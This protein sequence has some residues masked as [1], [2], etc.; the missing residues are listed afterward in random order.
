MPHAVTEVRGGLVEQDDG[1]SSAAERSLALDKATVEGLRRWKVRQAEE[2]LAAGPA[3]RDTGLVVTRQDG[4]GHR[5]KQLS[6]AFTTRVD[7]A[8]LPRVGVHRLRH[9]CATASLRAGI[10]PE[11][12][13]KRLGH[14]S[15]VVTLSIYA[16]VFEQDDRTAAERVAAAT[17][18]T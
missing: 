12:A 17:Y 8:G 9:S 13:S 6:S 18:G 16:H 15:V 4:T 7:E 3:W 10:S 1:R 14:S 5:P 11:V 2:R